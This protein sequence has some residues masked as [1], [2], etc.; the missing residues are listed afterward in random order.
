MLKIMIKYVLTVHLLGGVFDAPL[1]Y[2]VVKGQDTTTPK[3]TCKVTSITFYE[4]DACDYRMTT[5]PPGW[6]EL[7]T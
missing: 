5:P 1:S 3:T 6:D 7:L 4:G 2:V